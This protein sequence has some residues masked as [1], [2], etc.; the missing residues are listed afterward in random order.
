MENTQKNTQE[1]LEELEGN[2]QL[3]SEAELQQAVHLI[4]SINKIFMAGAGR[5][6]VAIRAFANRLTHLGKDVSVI[7]DVTTGYAN[8]ADELLIIGSGSGETDS[9]VA[10]AKK[11]AANDLQILLFTIDPESTI[12]NLATAIVK[13]P[14]ASPK[15]THQNSKG[16]SLQPMGSSF[17]QLCFLI[18]DGMVLSL[19][20]VLNESN[21]TMFARHANLE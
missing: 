2:L 4:A 14:G 3:V 20:D 16:T 10:L 13:L 12:A 21:E 17:E 6:G 5:S 7:G 9:L 11:A 18:Y 15:V 19:M 8:G 1:I